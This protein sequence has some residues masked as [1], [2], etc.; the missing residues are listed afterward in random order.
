M[1]KKETRKDKK[2]Q[3]ET[4]SKTKENFLFFL[5]RGLF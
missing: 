4:K 2:E 1:G 5:S 3:I